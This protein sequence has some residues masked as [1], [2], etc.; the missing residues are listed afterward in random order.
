MR[1]HYLQALCFM[2]LYMISLT[3]SANDPKAGLLQAWE[4]LQSTSVELEAFR[5]ISDKK[6]WV[7]FSSLPYEGELAILAYGTEEVNYGGLDRIPYSLTGYVEV[8]LVDAS[9]EETAKY[10]RTLAKWQQ[11]N[12]LFYN[13]ETRAWESYQAYRETLQQQTDELAPSSGLLLVFEYAEYILFAVLFYFLYVVINN[14]TR[15]KK[16]IALQEQAL[17]D[18][19][20]SKRIMKESLVLQRET[21]QLLQEILRSVQQHPENAEK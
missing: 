8:D 16:S 1:S 17:T 18:V 10:A 14:N 6:Y 2:L 19:E 5:K 13:Q 3:A 15:V 12:T 7:K 20:A 9:S 4:T 21:N 11:S